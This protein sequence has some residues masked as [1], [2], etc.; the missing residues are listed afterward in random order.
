LLFVQVEDQMARVD[1]EAVDHAHRQLQ[2]FRDRIEVER[3][4]ERDEIARMAAEV[5]TLAIK[6]RTRRELAR[7][8]LEISGIMMGE[9]TTLEAV[10]SPLPGLDPVKFVHAFAWVEINGQVYRV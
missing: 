3:R 1:C 4:T 7:A 10:D 6:C 9:K 5:G 8:R 2:S